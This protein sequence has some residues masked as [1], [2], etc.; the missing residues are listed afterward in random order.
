M[1]IP[2]PFPK[3]PKCNKMSEQGYHH[4]CGGELQIDPKTEMVFCPK[5]RKEWEIWN[6]SYICSCGHTFTSSDVVETLKDLLL[7][8]NICVAELQRQQEAKRD[9]EAIT[10]ASL[11]SFFENFFGKMGYFTGIAV[12]TIINAVINFFV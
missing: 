6:S 7:A 8:C 1:Y 11:R 4:N 10:K 3:C 9:R 12:G 2:L 5:C